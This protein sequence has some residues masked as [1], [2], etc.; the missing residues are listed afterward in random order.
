M[1]AVLFPA[2]AA[3]SLTA[4]DEFNTPVGSSE[5]QP[6]FGQATLNNVAIQSG[7]MNYAVQLGTRFAQEVPHSVTFA[8]NSSQ[9]DG[10]ARAVLDQQ[11]AWMQQFPELRFSV[12]GHTDLVGSEGYNQAL[13]KRRAQAVVAY[14][15]SRGISRSRLDALVSHGETQPL[16]PSPG[17][18]Q[19][20]RRAETAVSGFVQNQPTVMNGKYAEIVWRTLVNRASTESLA[21]RP[22]PQSAIIETQVTA[23]K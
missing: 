18:E 11:A 2:L 21:E 5:I 4:C 8:F 12:F 20:N 13:G 14:L 7:Q 10:A 15:G 22:H 19:A 9:L 3:L 6:A 16:V 23:T 1:R 17:P